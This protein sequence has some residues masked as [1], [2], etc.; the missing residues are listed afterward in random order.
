M[1]NEINSNLN[2]KD[3][4]NNNNNTNNNNNHRHRRRRRR[5]RWYC[6]SKKRKSYDEGIHQCRM[7]LINANV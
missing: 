4:D 7:K 1:H 5:C 2:E 3:N 6:D